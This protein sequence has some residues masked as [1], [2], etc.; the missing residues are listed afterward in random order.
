MQKLV[1]EK[2]YE[3]LSSEYVDYN[4]HLKCR[5]LNCGRIISITPNYLTK[6]KT[7]NGCRECG[8]SA[9]SKR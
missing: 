3:C 1:K 2:G 8:C 4:T 7:K 5:C 9:L 6:Q